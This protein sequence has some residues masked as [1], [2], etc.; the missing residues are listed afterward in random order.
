VEDGAHRRHCPAAMAGAA[1]ASTLHPGQMRV[2]VG[3]EGP[4][5]GLW[6]RMHANWLGQLGHARGRVARGQRR[7]PSG[8]TRPAAA[9]ARGAC[10]CG[11]G[12]DHDGRRVV[13]AV[14][15]YKR[16]ACGP[17]AGGDAAP[18]ARRRARSARPGVL[19]WFSIR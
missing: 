5:G 4:S 3:R 16:R 2:R 14:T 1:A 7:R 15:T 17:S 12:P 10:A 8:T 19:L 18:T 11:R 6:P 9:H 13:H